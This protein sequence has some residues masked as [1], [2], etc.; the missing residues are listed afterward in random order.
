MKHTGRTIIDSPSYM[1]EVSLTISSSLRM[2][3]L[4]NIRLKYNRLKHVYCSVEITNKMQLCNRTHYSTVHWRFN[5]FRA[6][7]RSSSGALTVFAASGLHTHVVTGPSLVWVRIVPTQTW[8]RP[9]T[10]CVCKPEA[11][12]TV[13]AL[14]DERYAAHVEPSMNG[15]IINSVTRLHLVVYFYRVILQCTDP[16]ISNGIIFPGCFI[17]FKIFNKQNAFS[18][19]KHVHNECRLLYLT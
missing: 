4:S 9:A 6:A 19:P 17:L 1:C 18:I 2:Y 13:R 11:S 10:T 3:I 15:G 12:N 5:M 8:L 7:Y 16:W 14:D